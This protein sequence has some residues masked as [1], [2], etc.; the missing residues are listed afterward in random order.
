MKRCA[1]CFG[2]MWGELIYRPIR[3]AAAGQRWSCLQCG[4]V[5]EVFPPLPKEIFRERRGRPPK[6]RA[7]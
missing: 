6:V 3:G 5:L 1:R 4:E 7:Q 2:Q